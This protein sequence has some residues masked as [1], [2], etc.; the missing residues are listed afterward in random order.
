MAVCKPRSFFAQFWVKMAS[1]PR[2]CEDRQIQNSDAIKTTGSSALAGDSRLRLNPAL[3]CATT[4]PCDP[5]CS[6]IQ[7][8]PDSPQLDRTSRA[9]SQWDV[10]NYTQ[11]QRNYSR[12]FVHERQANGMEWN[13]IRKQFPH[14]FFNRRKKD[15]KNK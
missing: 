1:N 9:P 4:A 6:R 2:S 10:S 8:S 7:I 13:A 5:Q 14:I 3:T 11:G 15:C 12:F